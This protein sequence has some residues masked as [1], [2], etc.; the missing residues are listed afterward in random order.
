MAQPAY[1]LGA[2]Y[3]LDQRTGV[4]YRIGLDGAVS[5]VSGYP[6]AMVG[7][8]PVELP[9][10]SDGYVLARGSR[11]IVNSGSHA[12]ALILFTDGSRPPLPIKSIARVGSK[13]KIFRIKQNAED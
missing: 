5:P 12:N 1:S 10:M 2:L 3:T 6:L 13:K 11:V 8:A 4:T 9:A 7:K